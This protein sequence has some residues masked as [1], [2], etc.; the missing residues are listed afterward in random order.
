MLR[1]RPSGKRLSRCRGHAGA[2]GAATGVKETVSGT[3]CIDAQTQAPLSAEFHW[4]LAAGGKRMTY[5]DRMELTALGT[6]AGILAPRGATSLQGTPGA[7][8]GS[9]AGGSQ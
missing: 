2:G 9:G 8:A 4:S 7:T 1:P 5:S 6:V 3:A